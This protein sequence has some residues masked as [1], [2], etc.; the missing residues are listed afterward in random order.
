VLAFVAAK[1]GVRRARVEP[2]R[3]QRLGMGIPALGAGG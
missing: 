2:H 1:P 3:L